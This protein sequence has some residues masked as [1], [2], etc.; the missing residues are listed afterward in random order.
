MKNIFL[1]LTL[2]SAILFTSC[3]G[4]PGPQGPPGGV[5]YAKVF[6]VNVNNY[7]YDGGVNQLYSSLFT[8]PFNVYESDA[9][10]AYRLSGTD[11]TI[12]PPGDVWTQ[13]PQSVFYNDGTGDFFQY[14]YNYSF[15]SVQFTIEGN[16]PLM[17]M[18][19]IDATG[20]VF[21]IAVVPAE[22]ARTNPSME[23]V[24][25]VMRANDG[26][27]DKLELGEVN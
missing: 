7:Q 6:E 21:R 15:L 18:D 8:Y 26:E 3:E 19:P 23:R 27:I 14:N 11:N 4:D 1:F 24:L 13:L 5:E 22:F 17:N 2:S 25:E 20:Q 16:F 10:L 12:N 9:V